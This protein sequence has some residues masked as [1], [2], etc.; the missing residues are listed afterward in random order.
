MGVF[1]AIVGTFT[2][3][4]GIIMLIKP[5]PKLGIPTRGKAGQLVFGGLVIMAIA[6]ELLPDKKTEATASDST[7]S[8]TEVAAKPAAPTMPQD[9]IAFLQTIMKYKEAYKDAGNDLKKSSVRR[10]RD[11]E[12]NGMLPGNAINNWT[13][14]L[15]DLGTNSDGNAYISIEVK[16]YPVSFKTWNNA[17]SDIGSDTLIPNG[18]DLYNRVAAMDEGQPVRF[19]G[20][21]LNE[22]SITETGSMLEPEYIVRFVDI[23]PQ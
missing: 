12:V 8:V 3:I 22:S 14:T 10:Q 21:L 20:R 4:A 17:L 18:S 9:Q 2:V 13:G 16:G 23:V 5:M 6:G 11:E 7:G 15:S 1:L 19:S